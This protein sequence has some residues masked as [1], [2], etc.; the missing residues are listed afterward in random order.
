MSD[1]NV[2]F[3]L[4]LV[5][6]SIHKKTSINMDLSG[7]D[8]EAVYD[9]A[10]N[11]S[12][13]PLLYDQIAMLSKQYEIP[14]DTMNKWKSKTFNS[15]LRECDK[16]RILRHLLSIAEKEKVR[17]IIF[18]GCALADLYPKYASRISGDTDILVYER[19]RENAVMVLEKAGFQKVES[20]SKDAVYIFF[21]KDIPY[22]IELH[23]SLW[24]D[25]KSA[26]I[27]LLEKMELTKEQSLIKMDACGMQITTLGYEE[28]LVFQMF[29]IIKHFSLQGVNIR[30][31]I[32]ITLYI[33]RY[34]NM[35]DLGSFWCKMEALNYDKFCDNFFA[36]CIRYLGLTSEVLQGRGFKFTKNTDD[37]LEDLINA[38]SSRDKNNS[39]WELLGTFAPFFTGEQELSKLKI[40]RRI[41]IVFP[42]RNYLPDKYHFAK[43]HVALLPIAWV[44]RFF[45]LSI[46]WLRNK[47]DWRNAK[48]KLKLIEHRLSLM[49][50][51]GLVDGGS[52]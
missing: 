22:E 11:N 44:H 15:M 2:K 1:N 3:V 45:S 42:S 6:N 20:L 12:I 27:D 14:E 17:L 33:E 47:D 50:S 25:Y 19:D 16:Y 28:H 46:K 29:H 4:S 13:V 10:R 30:Y 52:E 23:F 5:N 49:K 8:W 40:K 48:D 35:I 26:R 9:I 38:G 36:I 32:D 31:L 34:Q 51:L 7:I 37:F 41:N 24:E 18:K 43:K 39:N 21:H